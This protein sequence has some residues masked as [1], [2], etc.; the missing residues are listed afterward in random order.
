MGII[1]NKG[2]SRG[3][4]QVEDVGLVHNSTATTDTITISKKYRYLILARQASSGQASMLSITNNK[5]LTPT[6]TSQDSATAPIHQLY[7]NVPSGTIFTIRMSQ[8][9]WHTVSIFGIE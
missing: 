8:A 4:A 2:S 3:T 6:M 5:S 7:E 9:Y 1:Y